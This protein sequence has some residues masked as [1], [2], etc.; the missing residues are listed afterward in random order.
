MFIAY[1]KERKV[2][3]RLLEYQVKLSTRILFQ[4]LQ[5]ALALCAILLLFEV[6]CLFIP[7]FIR[8]DVITH[9]NPELILSSYSFKTKIRTFNNRRITK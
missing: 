9:T 6:T 7:I 8:K 5:I 4:K 1:W 2:V 3:N